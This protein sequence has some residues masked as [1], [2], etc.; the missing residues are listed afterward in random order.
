MDV[1]EECLHDPKEYSKKEE[2]ATNTQ[3]ST[4]NYFLNIRKRDSGTI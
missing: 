2:V 4:K 1:F 3:L